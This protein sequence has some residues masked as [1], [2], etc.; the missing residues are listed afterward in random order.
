MKKQF[1][2]IIFIFLISLVIISGEENKVF[3][4]SAYY[5][6]EEVTIN[7]VTIKNGYAPDRKILYESDY[8]IN[9]Y[10]K[11]KELI[12]A[13]TVEIPLLIYT[14]VITDG[15]VKG[16]LIKLN[17]TGFAL[18]LPYYEEAGRITISK[19][20]KKEASYS[21]NPVLS[22][23]NKNFYYIVGALVFMLI[24]FLIKKKN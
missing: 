9:I 22:F 2:F 3:I 20:S 11:E 19:G 16:N 21:L 24:V 6:N 13:K 8:Q 14:D 4:L 23:K 5:N 12:Y 17:Q 18:V 1:I 15:E 7:D 10:S